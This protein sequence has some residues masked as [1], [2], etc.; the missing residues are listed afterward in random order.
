MNKNYI[1]LNIDEI[2]KQAKNVTDKREFSMGITSVYYVGGTLC[3]D[4][5]EKCA[6]RYIVMVNISSESYTIYDAKT[7][8]ESISLLSIGSLRLAFELYRESK[9][10]KEYYEKCF[11]CSCLKHLEVESVS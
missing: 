7:K 9:V 4:I 3:I 2:L 10:N 11:E 6:L 1:M 8:S 5:F